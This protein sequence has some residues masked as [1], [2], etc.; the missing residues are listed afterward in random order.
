MF[1]PD[2]FKNKTGLVIGAGKSGVACANL[3]AAKG[4]KVLL[5]EEKKAEAVRERLKGLA[6]SVKVETGGH[7]KEAFNCGFA[8]KSPGLSQANTLIAALK[9]KKIP[10]FS[11][12]E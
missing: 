2:N 12:I 3:L 10:V 5:T 8:V 11:E 1:I 9:K 6:G 4:F 7:G